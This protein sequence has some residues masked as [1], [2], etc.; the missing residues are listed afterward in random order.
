MK[1]DATALFLPHLQHIDAKSK[2]SFPDYIKEI[3]ETPEYRAIAREINERY[4]SVTASNVYTD[5]LLE[6]IAP[7]DKPS[8][9]DV[10]ITYGPDGTKG[11]GGVPIIMTTSDGVLKSIG[12]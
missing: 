7:G 12:T 9:A 8:L 3:A 4:P 11:L 6:T 5:N 1:D 2:L 10:V